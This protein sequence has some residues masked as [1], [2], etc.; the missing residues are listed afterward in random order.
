MGTSFWGGGESEMSFRPKKDFWFGILIWGPTLYAICLVIQNRT[1]WPA[2]VVVIPLTAF[3]GSLWFG[4]V[5]TI[6]ETSLE[7]KYGPFLEKIPLCEIQR[8]KRTRTLW[9]SAALSF[10][11]LEIKYG[12]STVFISPLDTHKF[13]NELKQRCPETEFLGL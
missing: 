4:T 10:D 12:Y 1:I 8:V 9:S 3:V 11:R 2:L 7:I 5:Y 6:A 13:I